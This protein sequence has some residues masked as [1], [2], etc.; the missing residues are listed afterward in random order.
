M[1]IVLRDATLQ[2]IDTLTALIRAAFAEYHNKLDPPSGAHAEKPDQVGAKVAKGGATL[3]LIGTE[4]AGCVLYY[5]QDGCLYLGRL[6]V[7]PEYRQHG[8]GQALV[9]AVERKAVEMGLP[10]VQLSVRI[11]L[12]RNRAFFEKLG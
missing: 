12:P 10:G 4:Y 11:A 9:E 8:V 2:D 6:A 1:E 5:P 7:L 3:A